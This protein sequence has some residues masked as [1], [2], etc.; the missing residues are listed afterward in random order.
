MADY[1][2]GKTAVYAILG[3]PVAQVGSPGRFNALFR[4]RNHDGVMVAMRI[5]ADKLMQGFAGLRTIGNL[6]GLVF[7]IPHKLPMVGLVDKLAA[8]G[9]LVGAINAA[10]PGLDGCWIGD[11]FDGR[12]CAAAARAKGHNL[13]G[14]SVLQVG[15]GGVGRAIAFAFAEA[16]IARLSISDLDSERSRILADDLSSA[17]PAIATE[18]AAPRVAG[19]DVV[20]NASPLGMAESDPM[21]VPAADL[22]S[23]MLVIDVV[24]LDRPTPLLAA[25]AE[26]GA[27]TQNGH[28]MLAAQVGEIAS[29]F[30]ITT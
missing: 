17:F 14:R 10:K 29:F 23:G 16:G 12:G 22:A 18:V 4:E 28:A 2:S 5:G 8:N 25:A 24:L 7:T 26:R 27:A 20:V 13:A 9:Q 30:G 19:H 15:A 21:P 6:A 11:M 3:D 1:V